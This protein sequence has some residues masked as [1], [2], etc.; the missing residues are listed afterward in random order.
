[1]SLASPLFEPLTLGALELNN[2]VMMAPMTRARA[3]QRVPT[4]I[5]AD[6]YAQRAGC[7][8]I[9]T[10][11]TQVS[12]QGIGS[13]STPGIHTA[14]QIAGWRQVTDAV[15]AAG[16][17]IMLQIW[18]VGR[19]S[20]SSFHGGEPPVSASAVQANAHTFTANGYEAC[21]TPRALA[22]AEIP[23]VVAQ[24]RRGAENAIAAGFDGVQI[25]AA[26]GYL[27][28]QFLRDGVNRREDAYGGSVENRCR[29]LLEVTDAVCAAIGAERVSVRLSPFT[30]TF[31]CSD[32]DPRPLFFHAV[33]ELGRR[34]LAFLEI[35]ERG[36][37]PATAS[38]AELDFG[39]RSDELRALYGGAYVVNGQYDCEAARRALA[40]GHASAIAVGRPLISTP[41]LV[42]RWQ[43]GIEPNPPVDPTLWY[44]GDHTG[45]SDQPAVDMG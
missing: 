14:E 32:S 41:D 40:S 16:G 3:P 37:D 22:L 19:V 36:L 12:E 39:Y 7:G 2:R 21:S 23:E 31:D 30:N 33:T 29:F 4:A 38:D 5:M 25:H 11:A 18:H 27:I 17:R 45:Y 43:R 44:G 20:H 34:G 15:H 1:M 28:D 42:Q 26:N 9:I 24:Y 35:V 13:I 10:E 8:L 6:Y